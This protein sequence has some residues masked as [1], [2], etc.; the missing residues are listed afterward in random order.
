MREKYEDLYESW[1][2]LFMDFTE[3]GVNLTD[4]VGEQ[5]LLLALLEGYIDRFDISQSK[6]W[7]PT[8]ALRNWLSDLQNAGLDLQQFGEIDKSIWEEDLV[9]RI[10]DSRNGEGI[11][12]RLIGFSYGPCVDDWSV[13]I[14]PW[15]DYF[16]DFWSLIER[17]IEKMPG[18]WP[19]EE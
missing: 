5:T 7:A 13:W 19:S 6:V 18:E 11:G 4:V 9:W 10:L 14:S 16:T 15:D 3:I 2:S 12:Y 17:P 8:E 1:S